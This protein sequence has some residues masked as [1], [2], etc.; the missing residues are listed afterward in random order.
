MNRLQYVVSQVTV[1]VHHRIYK[2]FSLQSVTSQ[3]YPLHN[4]TPFIFEAYLYCPAT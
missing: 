2:R 4:L 1:L 3:L